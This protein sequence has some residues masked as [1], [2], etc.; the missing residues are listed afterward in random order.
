MNDQQ[1]T[2]PLARLW[3]DRSYLLPKHLAYVWSLDITFEQTSSG[4]DR[5]FLVPPSEGSNGRVYHVL[6]RTFAEGI[7]GTQLEVPVPDRDPNSVTGQA[8]IVADP[9]RAFGSFSGQLGIQTHG[10]VLQ[11]D[12]DGVIDLSA[13]APGRAVRAALHKSAFINTKQECALARYRWVA[14]RQFFGVGRIEPVY[15]RPD[16]IG[17]DKVRLSFDFHVGA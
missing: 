14:R 3:G 12:F 9:Y 5:T 13:A 7:D 1:A 4:I 8:T 6:D 15:I 17:P 10:R 11:M 2:L 16:T